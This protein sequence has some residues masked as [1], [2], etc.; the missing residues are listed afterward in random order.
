MSGMPLPASASDT[1]AN[2]ADRLRAGR[3]QFVPVPVF[4]TDP[5]EGQLYGAMPTYLWL[6]PNDDLILMGFTAFTYNP[7]V[8][9]FGGFGGLYFY[10]SAKERLM[11]FVQAAQRFQQDFSVQYINE[12]WLDER[13]TVDLLGEYYQDPFERFYGFGPATTRAGETNFVSRVWL[14]KARAAYT[15]WQDLAIQLEESWTRVRLGA[16]AIAN[17]TD[18]QT[19]FAGNVEVAA[20]NQ[21]THRLSLVWDSRDSLDIPTRG[22]FVEAA[23]LLAHTPQFRKPV[24]GGYN[25]V[26]K[27][28][29]PHNPHF[30]TVATLTM[31]QL[32]GAQIPFYM[33][34]NLGGEERLR[35]FVE[36]RF[37]DRGMILLDLEERILVK[38]LQMMGVKFDFS[39]DPFFSVGQ[40]F[41]RWG[42]IA[43]TTLQ[44]VGG[45][46]F[47]AKVPPS[48]V[49][50]IDVGIGR[51]RVEVYTTLG[52]AF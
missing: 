47:R 43:A 22:L 48:V 18:T 42:D 29:F 45:V 46:G 44:P 37:A 15:V 38:S 34:P 35:A 26:A 13:L 3:F 40:V 5:T 51:E 24:Y 8:A 30:T 25:F 39:I 31:Q 17:A 9:K 28:L 32:F 36:R 50:R 33:Q 11:L 23:G 27:K 16:A 49:G 52:Y 20:S 7:Q 10:P 2:F 1:F 12:R 14:G 41:H 4:A 6:A 21:W 19:A